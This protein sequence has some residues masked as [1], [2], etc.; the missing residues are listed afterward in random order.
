MRWESVLAWRVARQ[1]LARRSTDPLQVIS[2]ICGLHAQ[3][4]SSAQLTLWAR[5]QEP[6][7][8][9]DLLWKDPQRLVKTWA[10]RGTLHL[11]RT[12]ELPLYVGAQGGL[13][14]RYEQNA[15]L[16]HF[17]LTAE[18]AQSILVDVPN[19][20]R[21]GPL[22]RDELSDRV[23]AGLSRGYGDLL[24]PVAFRGDLI[25]AE[26]AG[27]NVRFA[28]PKPFERMPVEAATKE[29]ARRFLTRYG[30]AT[31]EDFA[32]WFGAPSPAAP[33]RW[34]KALGAEVTE[35]A[36]GWMLGADV[37][38]CEAAEPEGVVRLLPAF[39]QYV[40]AAPRDDRATPAPERIYRPGGWFSPV[41]LVDGV[42][43][44][45]WARDG[46]T[47]TIEPFA[48]VDRDA[49]EAEAARLPGTPTVI[50]HS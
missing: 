14:P 36:F 7:D 45:V 41:L 28:L 34:I 3:V 40:V 13:K 2:D 46:D 42:M 47:V 6:P 48:A 17:E 43:A 31:R 38:A 33:G 22:T 9:E 19:A 18:E 49:A 5:V 24:K 37:A 32:K 35:T 12:D 20:L 4:L 1:H 27:Q 15:W 44:G 23:H 8:V 39:D 26:S 29:L 16:R 11:L 30:P 50:W 25:F 21:A 10:M